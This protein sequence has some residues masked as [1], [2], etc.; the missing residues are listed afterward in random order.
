M[1]SRKSPRTATEVR[2][3]TIRKAIIRRGGGAR[4]GR[5]RPAPSRRRRLRPQRSGPGRQAPLPGLDRL[6]DALRLHR[7][8]GRRRAPEADRG[9]PGRPVHRALRDGRRPLH[10]VRDLQGRRPH[11]LHPR[12]QPEGD[13]RRPPGLPRPR[14]RRAS[15][16]ASTIQKLTSKA[17]KAFRVPAFGEQFRRPEPGGF[18]QVR[19]R[20]RGGRIRPV[21][22][23]ASTI[24]IPA[25]EKD[26]RATLRA[27]KK[28][29][30]LVDEFL[31]GNPHLKFFKG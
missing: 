15:S 29:L 7:E 31:L 16:R 21:P 18:L 11:R 22:S 24:P 13:L 25:S 14:H 26:F 28:N 17:A 3:E 6:Q 20:R 12:R 27:A 2:H 30:V 8:E 9:P 10:D 1:R 23:A 4:P 19:R 5:G